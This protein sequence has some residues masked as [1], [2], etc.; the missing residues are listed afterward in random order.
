ML[1]VVDGQQERLETQMYV[2]IILIGW[3]QH[4]Y[5]DVY[6]VHTKVDGTYEI[7]EHTERRW[8]DH[9]TPQSVVTLS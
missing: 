5:K 8:V 3:S 1:Y 4:G 9:V 7:T 6:M 2:M